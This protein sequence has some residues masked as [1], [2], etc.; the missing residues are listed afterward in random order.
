MKQKVSNYET[1]SL[2]VRRRVVCQVHLVFMVA[3]VGF[4]PKASK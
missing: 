2:F 4:E 3:A 1:E